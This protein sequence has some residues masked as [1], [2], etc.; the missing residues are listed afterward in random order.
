MYVDEV[1]GTEVTSKLLERIKVAVIIGVLL[2][3]ILV[4]VTILL[5]VFNGDDTEKSNQR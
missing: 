5:S 2:L 3:A 1:E 4:I